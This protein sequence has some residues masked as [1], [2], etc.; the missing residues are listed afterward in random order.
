MNES[1]VRC[2]TCFYYRSSQEEGFFTGRAEC[3]RFPPQLPGAL[4]TFQRLFGASADKLATGM[5]PRV[6]PYDWCGEWR[7]S[8]NF[9]QTV[10]SVYAT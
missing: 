2:E 8:E 4:S 7:S 5:F 1:A 10:E 3:R 9:D 6:D